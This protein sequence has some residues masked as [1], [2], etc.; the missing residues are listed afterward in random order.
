MSGRGWLDGDTVELRYEKGGRWDSPLSQQAVQPSL[1]SLPPR[2]SK[3]IRNGHKGN[4]GRAYTRKIGVSAHQYVEI[5]M[6]PSLI[7]GG[8]GQHL[9]PS[10]HIIT[11]RKWCVTTTK[12]MMVFTLLSN[13]F[14]LQ[15]GQICYKEVIELFRNLFNFIWPVQ[16]GQDRHRTEYQNRTER[17][18]RG[19]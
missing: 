16:R 9:R 8:G 10:V 12:K 7:I 2:S 1:N 18:D 15:G 11:L 4:Q 5:M 3:R 13:V 14:A 6:R 19:K 17:M